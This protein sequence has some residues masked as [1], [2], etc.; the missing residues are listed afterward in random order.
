[1]SE[2]DDA[3]WMRAALAQARAAQQAGE[4]PVGAVLV[5][6]GQVIASGRNAPLPGK[7][8]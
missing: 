6:G 7:T 2:T 4:V 1:M 8:P 3:H 5:Y